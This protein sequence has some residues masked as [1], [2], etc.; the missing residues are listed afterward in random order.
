MGVKAMKTRDR[1]FKSDEKVALSLTIIEESMERA[2]EA[3][4]I[5]MREQKK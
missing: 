1:N 5:A 3:M 4:A 2:S